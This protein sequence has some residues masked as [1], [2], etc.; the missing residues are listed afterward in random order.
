MYLEKLF[1]LVLQNFKQNIVICH[2]KQK[3][4]NL[5]NLIKSEKKKKVNKYALSNLEEQQF[6]LGLKHTFAHKSQNR[7]TLLAANME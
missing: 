1:F 5:I 2:L 6:K 3:S 7:K 4:R